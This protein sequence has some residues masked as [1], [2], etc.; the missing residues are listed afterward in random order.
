MNLQETTRE[1]F[2]NAV[3]KADHKNDWF[4]LLLAEACKKD[5]E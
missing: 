4:S 5:L 2:L 3:N 1:E